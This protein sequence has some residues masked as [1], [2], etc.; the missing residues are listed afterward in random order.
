MSNERDGDMTLDPHGFED[1][2]EF[3]ATIET[4]LAA[5]SLASGHRRLSTAMV[6]T[7]WFALV[8]FSAFAVIS[9]LGEP[10][11]LIVAVG[12]AVLAACLFQIDPLVRWQLNRYYSGV[13]GSNV[14]VEVRPSG[15]TFLNGDMTTEFGWTSITAIKANDEAVV[16]LKGRAPLATM[17]ASAFES[18][19]IRDAF[20]SMVRTRIRAA[21]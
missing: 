1:R 8:A 9:R 10:V 13:F 6:L 11:A 15:M 18:P 4:S 5:S 2:F 7:G 20:V 21:A 14:V 17:P 19:A 12:I 16:F 3:Q